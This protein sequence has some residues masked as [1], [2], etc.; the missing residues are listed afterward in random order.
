MF[1]FPGS[2]GSA[3]WGRPRRARLELA[4]HFGVV[5]ADARSAPAQRDAAVAELREEVRV[6]DRGAEM[7]VVQ[8]H[9]QLAVAVLHMSNTM[10]QEQAIKKKRLSKKKKTKNW[11]KN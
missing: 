11:P 1:F 2:A 3:A 4:T 6:L 7:R 5:L 9:E 10:S 8:T